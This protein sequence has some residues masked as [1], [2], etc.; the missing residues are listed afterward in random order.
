MRKCFAL[1]AVLFLAGTATATLAKE[2]G[3]PNQPFE[4][5]PRPGEA[6]DDRPAGAWSD[7]N[8][9]FDPDTL[10]FGDDGGPGGTA[11]LGDVWDFNDG[12]LQGWYSVDVTEQSTAFFRQITA[13]IWAT[14]GNLVSAPLLNG[15]GSL[16]VGAF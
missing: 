4:R 16:W 1:M 15:A 2:S 12:T 8:L 5:A 11:V 6:T 7:G 13:A 9:R 10:F 14:G 3:G